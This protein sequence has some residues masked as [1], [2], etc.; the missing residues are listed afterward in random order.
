MNR[1][2][3]VDESF[4]SLAALVRCA[5][6]APLEHVPAP[7]S[8]APRS[9]APFARSDIVHELVLMRLAA[10]EAFESGTTRLLRA[11]A[12][13]V[14][15]RELSVSAADV[16]SLAARLLATY[17]EHEPIEIVVS[18]VDAERVRV[19]LPVRVDPA[20]VAGDLVVRVRDG[21]F[22]SQFGFRLESALERA[23][24]GRA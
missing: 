13:D 15:G 20:L 23:A 7:V 12:D 21:A 2:C 19:P 11:L 22:E 1:S 10:I 3:G 5:L 16:A 14:L 24:D 8:D 4:I 18:A 6:A 17:G 9:V